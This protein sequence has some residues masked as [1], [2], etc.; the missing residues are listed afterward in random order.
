VQTVVASR[1]RKEIMLKQ[2]SK[3]WFH[4]KFQTEHTVLTKEGF[5]IVVSLPFKKQH[6][7]DAPRQGNFISRGF[8]LVM[9]VLEISGQ[10]EEFD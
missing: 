3:I 8:S 2:S 7:N 9:F 1:P 4:F 10:N 5:F 6:Q